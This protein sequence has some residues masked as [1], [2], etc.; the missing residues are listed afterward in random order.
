MNRISQFADARMIR[1]TAARKALRERLCVTEGRG[2]RAEDPRTER[3]GDRA[4]AIYGAIDEMVAAMGITALA[5]RRTAGM[6]SSPI[7]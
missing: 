3:D 5:L 7:Q 4:A 2:S 1:P 6:S